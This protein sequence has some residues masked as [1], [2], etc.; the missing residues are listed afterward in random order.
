MFAGLQFEPTRLPLEA[1]ALRAE[2]REFVARELPPGYWPNSDFNE[3][4]SPDFSGRL[5]E[6][7]WDRNDLAEALRRR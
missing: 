3:G 1:E 2:V 5:G 6:R 4:H 7:G